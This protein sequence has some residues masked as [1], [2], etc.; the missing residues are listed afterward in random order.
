MPKKFNILTN[1]EFKFLG[2]LLSS[3]LYYVVHSLYKFIRSGCIDDDYLNHVT[4]IELLDRTHKDI[5][6]DHDY[7]D[8]D[9]D[10]PST[11]YN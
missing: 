8:Q 5:M 10:Q 11:S 4:D 7:Y 6:I 9:Q 1:L 2:S 3:C